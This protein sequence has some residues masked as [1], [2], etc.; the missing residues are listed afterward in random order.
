MD[1]E[2]KHVLSR[3]IRVAAL[4]IAGLPLAAAAPATP[5]GAKPSKERPAK[6]EKRSI[7]PRGGRDLVKKAS[8]ELLD[9]EE[10]IRL[11]E[12]EARTRR[13]AAL[14]RLEDLAA[15]KRSVERAVETLGREVKRKETELKEKT[16]ALAAREKE[17]S[18]IQ[19]EASS[20]AEP[21]KQYL[22]H[23]E[24]LVET[25]IPWKVEERKE[26][27]NEVRKKL[28]APGFSPSEC[29]AALGRAEEE[30]EALGRLVEAG[31]VELTLESEY[32]PA[33]AIHLGLLG[34]IFAGEGSMVGYAQRGQRLEEG[35]GFL[36]GKPG[37]AE[38]VRR[39]LEMARRERAPGIVELPLPALPREGEETK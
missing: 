7:T 17:L 27:F 1:W 29:L 4:V 18:R 34:V 10:K 19:H 20:L 26:R 24:K 30:E 28:S 35:I 8:A 23:A 32:L 38:T 2:F 39:A 11:L 33:P 13:D 5:D 16:D 9:L 15:E 25:G 22:A 36:R 12:S 21:M 6:D 31:T 3:R 14:G 37:A